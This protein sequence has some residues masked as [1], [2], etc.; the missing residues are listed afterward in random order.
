MN[1]SESKW[2]ILRPFSPRQAKGRWLEVRFSMGDHGEREKQFFFGWSSGNTVLLSL[3]CGMC[4]ISDE[5]R[6]SR[7]A[8]ENAWWARRKGKR[9]VEKID[10]SYLYLSF[11]DVWFLW[12]QVKVLFTL[13]AGATCE[14]YWSHQPTRNLWPVSFINHYRHPKFPKSILQKLQVQHSH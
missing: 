5:R 8:V 13:L 6:S 11:Q 14:L 1:R 2:E 7:K 9:K 12:H 4:V 10:K 3:T